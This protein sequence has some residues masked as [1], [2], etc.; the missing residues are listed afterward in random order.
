MIA[1]V[2]ED[3]KLAILTFVRCWFRLLAA[4]RWDEACALLDQPNAANPPWTPD[5]IRRVL[6]LSYPPDGE[7]RSRQ[8]GRLFF[9][10]PDL[11]EGDGSPYFYEFDNGSDGYSFEHHVPL[12]GRWSDVTAEFTFYRRAEGFLVELIDMHIM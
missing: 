1:G 12:N 8:A 5:E 10:D 4:G 7:F 2:F 6:D 9:T 3:P 11:L